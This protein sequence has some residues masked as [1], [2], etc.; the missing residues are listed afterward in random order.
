M[1]KGGIAHG[2]RE[3][4]HHLHGRCRR[5][6]R[7]RSFVLRCLLPQQDRGPE[8]SRGRFCSE[9]VAIKESERAQLAGAYS[10]CGMGQSIV[11][12]AARADD[13][14]LRDGDSRGSHVYH[15]PASVRTIPDDSVHRDEQARPIHL[16]CR[17]VPNHQRCHA[18]AD[19]AGAI[20]GRRHVR[21]EVHARY[22][23]VG[24]DAVFPEHHEARSRQLGSKRS[25]LFAWS[26]TCLRDLSIV[27]RRDH[28][29]AADRI[30]RLLVP[31]LIVHANSWR[32]RMLS[33]THLLMWPGRRMSTMIGAITLLAVG[34]SPMASSQDQS[35][36][37]AK[38][39]IFAR[40]ILMDTINTNMDELE[41]MTTSNKGVDLAEG[42]EHAD[43]IS[44]MLMAFP[45]LFPAS[46]NQWK[47]NVERDPGR[48]TY[49]SPDLFTN[50]A[51]F[52]AR[53]AAAAK[54]AYR[55]SRAQQDGDF[56]TYVAE[57]R[58]A[59]DSCH[60]LYLK[61]DQ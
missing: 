2:I 60:G 49:A 61:S 12:L 23:R 48:D 11:G 27:G 52:Y 16:V 55:A 22:H 17:C 37:I 13:P 53:A 38:D 35:T 10:V 43:L 46:T 7:A 21:G 18:V 33:V 42:R 29:G 9:D 36:T 6:L 54:T 47:P 8:R 14:R 32:C 1:C 28:W 45:H 30:S 25:R 20:S 24:R 44:V 51:D 19:E 41:T 56:K 57:L 26:Q 4:R 40:K 39:A 50:Y 59:C 31:G 5:V 3:H 15:R 34:M 58:V